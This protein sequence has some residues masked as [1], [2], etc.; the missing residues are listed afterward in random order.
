MEQRL[1]ALEK[2][3][4]ELEDREA[5]RA[6]KAAYLNACDLKQP[7]AVRACFAEG[8]VLIDY[9]HIGVFHDRD[10]FVKVFE[11]MGCHAHVLD[12]HHGANPHIEL[13]GDN[14][15]RG[16]WALHYQN[17]DANTHIL[18]QLVAYYEDEY[19]RTQ[20]GW[21]ISATTV[22]FLSTMMRGPDG[23]IQYVGN[24]PPKP[25]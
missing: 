11:E 6:L 2:R 1:E 17:I 3:M 21:R 5:I 25:E 19:Q 14:K 16:N 10:A 13:A 15:A 8:D 24:A 7:A 20:D 23:V 18:T 4:R 22:R 9:G 12:M